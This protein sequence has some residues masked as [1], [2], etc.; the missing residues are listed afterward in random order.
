MQTLLTRSG[1]GNYHVLRYSNSWV[2]VEEEK[3]FINKG[4]IVSVYKVSNMT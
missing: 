1:K 3:I 4:K 2:T